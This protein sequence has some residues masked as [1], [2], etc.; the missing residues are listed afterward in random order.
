MLYYFSPCDA[1]ET[2]SDRQWLE[3]YLTS[4]A[5]LRALQP[6][7]IT[8]HFAGIYNVATLDRIPDDME[9]CDVADLNTYLTIN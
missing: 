8:Q 2:K 4:P 1:R 9:P 7:I 6:A 3:Y 5:E